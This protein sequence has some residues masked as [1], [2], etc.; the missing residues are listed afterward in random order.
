MVN[1]NTIY[2]SFTFEN[3]IGNAQFI[4]F[5]QGINSISKIFSAT[6]ARHLPNAPIQSRQPD[7]RLQTPDSVSNSAWM[8]PY[9]KRTTQVELSYNPNSAR[10]SQCDHNYVAEGTLPLLLFYLIITLN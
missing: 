2:C 1:I 10:N 5:L 9:I 3:H 8:N 6:K 4:L 7:F